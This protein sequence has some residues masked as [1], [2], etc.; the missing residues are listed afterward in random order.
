MLA[1]EIKMELGEVVMKNGFPTIQV[2]PEGN[3]EWKYLSPFRGYAFQVSGENG[4]D[5]GASQVIGLKNLV[6]S[7]HNTANGRNSSMYCSNLS[8][9]SS[10]KYLMSQLA[11]VAVSRY[12]DMETRNKEQRVYV[13]PGL[14]NYG[15]LRIRDN[16]AGEN[17]DEFIDKTYDY[18]R[19]F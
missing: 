15:T 16:K 14:F 11:F 1:N 4:G 19:G 3:T 12:A 10:V 8:D 18:L 7:Y 5:Y 17:F 6:D 13:H 9:E 2:R